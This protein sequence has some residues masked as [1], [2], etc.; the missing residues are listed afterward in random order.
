MRQGA[1]LGSDTLS[2]AE[3]AHVSALPAAQLPSFPAFIAM[4][5]YF[6]GRHSLEEM[7]M[8]ELISRADLEQLLDDFRAVLVLTVF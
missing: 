3:L 8:A 2:E 7:M 1:V 4:C 6:R 5:K